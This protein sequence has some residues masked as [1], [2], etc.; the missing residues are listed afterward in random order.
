MAKYE[1]WFADEQGNR[2]MLMDEMLTTTYV[3]TPGAPGFVSVTMPYIPSALYTDYSQPDKQ[4]HIYRAPDK[5]T[6]ALL[7]IWSVRR[8]QF[9]TNEFG[10]DVVKLSG[11]GVND[12]L[13]RRII[14]YYSGTAQTKFESVA[15]DDIMKRIVDDQLGGDADTDYDGNAITSRNIEGL[16]FSIQD[17]SSSGPTVDKECAWQPLYKT[18][19]ELQQQS[20]TAGTEVFFGIDITSVSPWTSQFRTKTGQPG[21][22]RSVTT[23]TNP[24]T[25]GRDWGNVRRPGLDANYFDEENFEY[26]GGQGE[27][28]KRNIQEVSDTSKINLSAWNR[29]EGFASAVTSDTDAG[30]QAAGNVRLSA[31]RSSISSS[32]ELMDTEDTPFGGSGWHA[33]D[34]VT[35]SQYGTQFDAI[36][37][38]VTGTITPE[39]ER[40]SG[41]PEKI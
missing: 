25:F 16:N 7:G 38:S 3:I 18:L 14:A 2:L 34:R 21:A 20:K 23:G 41:T 22:D 8:W 31:Q 11:A 9:D 12:L 35:I 5:G 40:I 29:R 39:G 1:I 6:L 33:G 28:D 30:V 10:R 4:I 26:A 15:V 24:L 32:G 36:V 13:D 27:G 19:Q 37:R 17:E